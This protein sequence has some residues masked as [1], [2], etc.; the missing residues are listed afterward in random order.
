M[1]CRMTSGAKGD[2]V[3]GVKIGSVLV[4]MMNVQRPFAGW[5]AAR[6]TAVVVSFP[7]RSD[8]GLCPPRGVS[9]CWRESR[10]AG[11]S[12][13][14][15]GARLRTCAASAVVVKGLARTTRELVSAPFARF[16]WRHNRPCSCLGL[17]STRPTTGC[18]ATILGRVFAIPPTEGAA[19]DRARLGRQGDVSSTTHSCY[20]F[21]SACVRAGTS[22][23][24]LRR[25]FALAVLN[26]V[27]AHNAFFHDPIIAHVEM[28]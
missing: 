25:W 17:D 16:R 20:A 27:T 2:E 8:E 19:A 14:G 3:L 22:L 23:C 1:R 5:G 12:L 6:S 4:D 11:V 13:P 7:N 10:S 9:V 15:V 21:A 24:V 28:D 26:S 18:A